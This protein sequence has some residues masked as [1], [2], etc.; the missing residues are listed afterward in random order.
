MAAD[1]LLSFLSMPNPHAQILGA[2]QF[3]EPAVLVSLRRD[4]DRTGT[5]FVEA[6]RAF[7]LPDSPPVAA[8]GAHE[9]RMG[10]SVDLAAPDLVA[11]QRAVGV[12]RDSLGEARCLVFRPDQ[13]LAFGDV[14]RLG[15]ALAAMPD[16]QFQLFSELA[17]E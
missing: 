11:V 16:L 8:E 1:A 15:E 9:E 12:A 10:F 17:S 3:R 14:V 13:R 6:H 2:C 5:F 7:G 4:D